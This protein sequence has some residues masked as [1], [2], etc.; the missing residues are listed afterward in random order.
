M[1]P[2]RRKYDVNSEKEAIM[3]IS[4]G[5]TY[6]AV[7]KP[8]K[9]VLILLLMG[10][11]PAYVAFDYFTSY[12]ATIKEAEPVVR[13]TVHA[14]AY[15]DREEI[16]IRGQFYGYARSGFKAWVLADADAILVFDEAN[17]EIRKVEIQGLTRR[18][19]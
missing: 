9:T 2:R 15:Q 18:K 13:P 12:R 19:K 16:L 1:T 8:I 3:A 5:V 7:K 11:G 10:F 4:A 6:F 17:G 14:V